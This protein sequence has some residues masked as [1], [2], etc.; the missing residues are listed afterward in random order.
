MNKIQKISIITIALMAIVYADNPGPLWTDPDVVIDSALDYQDVSVATRRSN[1]EIFV[2]VSGKFFQDTTHYGIKV[3]RS[4]DGMNWSQFLWFSI[5][6]G[7]LYNPSMAIFTAQDS[8]FLYVAYEHWD[9]VANEINIRAY[10]RNLALSSGLFRDISVIAGVPERDPSLCTS[11]PAHPNS[12]WLFCAFESGDS[13]AFARSADYGLTW[14]DRQ[15]I[16][17]AAPEYRFRD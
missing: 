5:S 14:T 16:S 2:A 7:N 8:E 6:Q 15:N 1:G 12:P 11:S 9:T 4:L 10:R 3:Y 17:S 13:I